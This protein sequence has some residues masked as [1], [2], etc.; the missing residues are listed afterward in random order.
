MSRSNRLREIECIESLEA[1]EKDYNDR[2]GVRPFNISHWDPTPEFEEKMLPY[3]DVPSLQALIPYKFSYQVDET[4]SV[5]E[6]LGGSPD[7]H[8]G[9]F[10]ASNTTSILCTL[11]WL[12]SRRESEIVVSCPAYFSLFYACRRFGLKTQAVHLLR[13]SGHFM[14]PGPKAIIWKKPAVLWLTNPVYGTGVYLLPENID[15]IKKLLTSG[16]TVICDECLSIAGTELVR[17]LGQYERFVSIYSPHKGICVNGMKFS[18]I[19]FN[20][21]YKVFM[22]RWNDVWSGGLGCSTQMAIA[23]YLSENFDTYTSS[24]L[25]A[26][27]PQQKLLAQLCDEPL[28]E[29]DLDAAGHF[30]SCY[31]STVRASQGYSHTFLAK[32]IQE[33][34]G[35]IITGNRSR[36]TRDVGFSF[37][38]NLARSGPKFGATLARIMKFLLNAADSSSALSL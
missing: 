29:R 17:Q 22:E 26:I 33:T 16:W 7:I 31:L 25:E 4:V 9:V 12:V 18:V 37:R 20:K 3:L 10:N 14:L 34:G 1:V 30:V 15:F 24:F 8:S 21:R 19:V 35:S 32:L 2:F 36:M 13:R 11:N 28:I 38:V 5:I 6:K 23:H 27:A